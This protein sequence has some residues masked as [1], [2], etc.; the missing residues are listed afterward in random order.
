[1]VG[2]EGVERELVAEGKVGRGGIRFQEG[3]RAI[4]SAR[5]VFRQIADDI[6]RSQELADLALEEFLDRGVEPRGEKSMGKKDPNRLV[7]FGHFEVERIEPT[8]QILLWAGAQK[9]LPDIVF[10]HVATREKGGCG[11]RVSVE[12]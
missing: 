11:H 6:A 12:I 3:R 7:R 2:Q 10:E 9:V 1:L 4:G 5:P 8:A